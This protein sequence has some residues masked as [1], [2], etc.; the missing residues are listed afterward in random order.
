DVIVAHV[1]THSRPH[2]RA[3]LGGLEVIPPAT[4]PY[5]GT[6]VREMDLGAV[7][8]RRPQVALVDDFA[9]RN[10]PGARHSGRWQ[11]VAVLL[12]AGIEVISTVRI[13]HLDSLADVVAKIT[14]AEPPRSAPDPVV[15][16]ADEIEMVDLAPEV[17]RDR[18]A[19]G[20]IC[21]WPEA[22]AALGA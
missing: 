17:L 6:T 20:Q 11:D 22:E 21:A 3:L 9:H 2:T 18:M 13:D 14:G 7:L 4:V 16:A 10:V 1:G 12:G 5:R 19:R 15:R 8:A